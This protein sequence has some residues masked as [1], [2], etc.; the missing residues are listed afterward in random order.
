MALSPKLKKQLDDIFVSADLSIP[1][2]IV[3]KEGYCVAS[4][5]LARINAY[6]QD[7]LL[8]WNR[9]ESIYGLSMRTE[10]YEISLRAVA[11][12][13]AVAMM[14]KSPVFVK[15]E[16][17]FD[18]KLS[19]GHVAPHAP[20]VHAVKRS[21]AFQWLTEDYALCYDKVLGITPIIVPDGIKEFV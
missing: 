16:A 20:S 17:V 8:E 11:A 19:V 1:W 18:F 15:Y 7:W 5:L 9:S 13:D 10:G 3:D 14:P 4:P 12:P 21:H 2:I 6:M